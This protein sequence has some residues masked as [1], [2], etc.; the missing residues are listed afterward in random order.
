LR[1]QGHLL[2]TVHRRH[3]FKAGKLVV[4]NPDRAG[5]NDCAAFHPEAYVYD[6]LASDWDVVD[7]DEKGALGNPTQDVY[8]LRKPWMPAM[9]PLDQRLEECSV[10][11]SVSATAVGSLHALGSG[12]HPA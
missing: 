7:F 12:R 2:L 6:E 1:P 3:D 5:E 10:E 4:L 8:L 11:T 9:E